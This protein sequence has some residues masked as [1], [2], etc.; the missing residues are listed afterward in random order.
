MSVMEGLCGGENLPQGLKPFFHFSRLP[1]R[2]K[3]CPFK[4]VLF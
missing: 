3:P 1:A 4:A 2:L